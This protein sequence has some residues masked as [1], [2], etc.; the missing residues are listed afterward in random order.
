MFHV[1]DFIDVLYLSHIGGYFYCHK[2]QRFGRIYERE[3]ANLWTIYA[4]GEKVLGVKTFSHLAFLWLLLLCNDSKQLVSERSSFFR[5]C[6]HKMGRPLPTFERKLSDQ[7]AV[8]SPNIRGKKTQR[9]SKIML[10]SIRHLTR[11]IY[12]FVFV[13]IVDEM[14]FSGYLFLQGQQKSPITK[15]R[16]THAL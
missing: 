12:K 8:S 9:S 14:T 4:R 6:V 15:S 10:F 16:R 11:N 7:R 3:Q 13:R 2:P 1:P 5:S